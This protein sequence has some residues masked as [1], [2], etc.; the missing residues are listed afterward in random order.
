MCRRWKGFEALPAYFGGKRRLCGSIFRQIARAYPRETW[1][2]LRFVDP[3]LGGG[4]VS[5]YAK[6]LGFEVLCG[7]LAWRSAVIGKALI[8]NSRQRIGAAEIVSLFVPVAGA[9]TM[10]QERFSPQ[11]FNPE[12]AS[13]L[14]NA[15]AAARQI[16]EA[17]KR[18][19]I[20]LLL[21]KYIFALRPHSKFSS[22]GA[23]NRPFAEGRWDDIKPTYKAAVASN[24]VHPLLVLQRLAPKVNAGVFPGTQPCRAMHAEALE[25]IGA[26]EGADVLYLDPPYGGTLAYEKEYQV[27]DEIFGEQIVRSPYSARDGLAYFGELLSHCESYRL[28]VISYG[29]AA[30]TLDEVLAMVR[31]HRPAEAIEIRYEHLA[32]VARQKKRE[33]NREFI[34]LAGKGVSYG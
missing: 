5:L 27:L 7:D 13:F 17:T 6:L 23:F 16:P 11:H 31:R 12:A 30:A 34:I 18:A 28:W 1:R 33:V 4:S 2:R 8:E 10:I 21:V 14:D 26:G 29:N 25:T 9:G 3:F 24:A 20:E 32:A 22:P 19:L 15:I